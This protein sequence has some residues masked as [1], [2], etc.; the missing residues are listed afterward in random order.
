[1]IGNAMTLSVVSLLSLNA[2]AAEIHPDRPVLPAM[3][4]E[5]DGALSM[6]RNPANLGF[7]PDPSVAFLYG[8]GLGGDGTTAA[9]RS[10]VFA[11]SGGPLGLGVLYFS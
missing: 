8:A 9:F 5:E 10:F 11:F 2:Y 7:D 1:M 3:S 6:W 4:L